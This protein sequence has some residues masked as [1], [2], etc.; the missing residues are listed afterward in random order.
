MDTKVKVYRSPKKTIVNVIVHVILAIL[1]F[2]WL[3]PIVWIVL[4]SFRAE[5]GSY[6]NTFFPRPTPLIIT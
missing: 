6:V 3:L 4:T 1:A 2:V 5:K